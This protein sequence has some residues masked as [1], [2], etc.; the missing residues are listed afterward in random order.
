MDRRTKLS[1]KMP[2][3]KPKNQEI[4]FVAGVFYSGI[5]YG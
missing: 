2:A 3:H 5:V 4:R 1:K